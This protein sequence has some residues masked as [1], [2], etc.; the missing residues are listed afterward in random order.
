MNYSERPRWGISFN[1][2]DIMIFYFDNIHSEPELIKLAD[3]PK[4]LHRLDFLIKK[5]NVRTQRDVEIS[6]AAGVILRKIYDAL[7][8]NYKEETEET[9]L[10]QEH[11][12]LIVV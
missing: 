12:T 2:H 7:K 1:F 5:K 3:L 11:Y 6:I 4:E 10:M 9:L 8:K